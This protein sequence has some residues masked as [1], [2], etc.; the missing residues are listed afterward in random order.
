VYEATKVLR[1][2]HEV[3]L[4]VLKATEAAANAIESGVDASAQVLSDVVEFLRLYADR[5]HHGKRRSAFP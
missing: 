5:Q 4:R 1:D 2:E 3:I